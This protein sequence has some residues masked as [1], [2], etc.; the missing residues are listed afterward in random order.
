MSCNLTASLQS[1]IRDQ[2]QRALKKLKVIVSSWKQSAFEDGCTSLRLWPGQ[3]CTCRCFSCC[4]WRKARTQ[5]CCFDLSFVNLE[6]PS[7]SSLAAKQVLLRDS[8]QN[9]ILGMR[10]MFIFKTVLV[11][12]DIWSAHPS[13]S[14]YFQHHWWNMA[15]NQTGHK[16]IVSLIQDVC[17]TRECVWS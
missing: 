14:C 5:V 8:Q 6:S 17:D 4:V 13:A 10:Q 12:K 16:R 3:S 15:Q 11:G 9:P 2:V 1:A 7:V